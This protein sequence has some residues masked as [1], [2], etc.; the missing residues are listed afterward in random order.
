MPPPRPRNRD[1]L[2]IKDADITDVLNALNVLLSP[3]LRTA[4]MAPDPSTGEVDKVWD[5]VIVAEIDEEER[6]D[7]RPKYEESTAKSLIAEMVFDVRDALDNRHELQPLI[8]E[9]GLYKVMMDIKE[10]V[11]DTLKNRLTIDALNVDEQGFLIEPKSELSKDG[12]E[13]YEQWQQISIMLVENRAREIKAM[14]DAPTTALRIR[15]MVTTMADEG[16]ITVPELEAILYIE[17][18]PELE[19]D[20]ARLLEQLESNLPDIMRQVAPPAGTLRRNFAT[21]FAKATRDDSPEFRRLLPVFGLTE[22]EVN[23]QITENKVLKLLTPKEI[24]GAISDDNIKSAIAAHLALKEDTGRFKADEYADQFQGTAVAAIH[25][26]VVGQV[27]EGIL[28][29]DKDTPGLEPADYAQAVLEKIATAADGFRSRVEQKRDALLLA[30]QKQDP[31]KLKRNAFLREAGY[32]ESDFDSKFITELDLKISLDGI[33]SVT[34]EYDRQVEAGERDFLASAKM[35]RINDSIAGATDEEISNQVQQQLQ[36]LSPTGDIG[37]YGDA[38][39]QEYFQSNIAPQIG[40]L[41]RSAALANPETFNFAEYTNELLGAPEVDEEGRP[42]YREPDWADKGLD[43]LYEEQPAVDEMGRPVDQA[44]FLM[45]QTPTVSEDYLSRYLSPGAVI[46]R[47]IREERA[48]QWL[49]DERVTGPVT[50]EQFRMQMDPSAP[51]A[52]P[53]LVQRAIGETG[54]PFP[55]FPT[56]GQIYRPP[57]TELGFAERPE[58]AEAIAGFSGDDTGFQSSI[59]K[60]LP[61]LYEEFPEYAEE[62]RRQQRRDLEERL[63]G[64]GT[65]GVVEKP[66]SVEGA[67]PDPRRWSGVP[68]NVETDKLGRQRTPAAMG[69]EG[70]RAFARQKTAALP[71]KFDFLPFLES[72]IP[73][74]R[75]E[76]ET[77][78][79]YLAEQQREQQQQLADQL[80]IERQ[81]GLEKELEKEQVQQRSLRRGRTRIR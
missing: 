51:P 39:F 71:T 77:S 27:N 54:A 38:A 1:A 55:G 45:G 28:D 35:K 16:K 13:D 73:G 50:P 7:T 79:G 29:V 70:I 76:Y 10:Q 48:G 3:S 81:A 11:I 75:R 52:P 26:L 33:N 24:G 17:A 8:T 59:I 72:R 57:P 2:E 4:Y 67:K 18:S 20:S 14:P 58:L 6:E 68:S 41:I 15:K 47:A 19:E 74:I 60:A 63:M 37:P 64:L 40:P 56:G 5:K 49:P 42:I 30:E 78:P 34:D 32:T 69:I 21:Q 44:Q 12:A 23:T 25:A 46:K 22:E 66:E 65:R 61:G 62:Q 9:K 36:Q 80:E 31:S 53:G 43:T